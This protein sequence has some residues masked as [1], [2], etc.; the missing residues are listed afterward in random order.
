MTCF[1]SAKKKRSISRI[2]KRREKKLLEKLVNRQQAHLGR[3]NG[4]LKSSHLKRQQAHTEKAK[5]EDILRT[6]LI[7]F[8]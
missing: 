7:V 3:G 6:K 2:R 8:R 4:P 1:V 5:K